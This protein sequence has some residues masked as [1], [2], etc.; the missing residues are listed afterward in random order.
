[1]SYTKRKQNKEINFWNTTLIDNSTYKSWVDLQSIGPLHWSTLRLFSSEAWNHH[2]LIRI[3]GHAGPTV[4]LSSYVAPRLGIS[5]GTGT[6]TS[7]NHLTD[8][9]DG[10]WAELRS[11]TCIWSSTL[12]QISI[13][14]HLRIVTVP[15]VRQSPPWVAPSVDFQLSSHTSTCNPISY[16]YNIKH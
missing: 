7:L 1:M 9:Q 5:S 13:M 4:H 16:I 6:L 15:T 2:S 12:G 14:L 8:V 10:P 3:N 11:V